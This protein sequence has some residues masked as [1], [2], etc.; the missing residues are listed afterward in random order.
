M[1]RALWLLGAG[2]VM[3]IAIPLVLGGSGLG[4]QLRQF[5]LDTFLLML[6]M[7]VMCWNLNAGRL[8]LLLA[9]RGGHL[10]QRRA[11]GMVMATEFAISATPGGSGGPLT[12]MGLLSRQ[13]VRP[14]QATAVFAGDQFTDM[15]LCVSALASIGRGRGVSKPSSPAGAAV[16]W[17]GTGSRSPM[18]R[19]CRSAG[20]VIR[21][22]TSA[23]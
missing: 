14:A 22:A 13:G 3:V 5:P 10:G 19:V 11:V 21:G 18:E 9:G 1:N 12:L 16:T 20:I 4:G 17:P 8:R 23:C 7:I 15:L 6:G 2:L